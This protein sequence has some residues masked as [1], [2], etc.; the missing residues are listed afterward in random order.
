MTNIYCALT[1]HMLWQRVLGAYDHISADKQPLNSPCPLPLHSS[2]SSY[3][4]DE[5]TEV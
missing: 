1:V 2:S 3:F 5:K 4:A